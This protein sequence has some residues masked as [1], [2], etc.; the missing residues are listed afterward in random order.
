MGTWGYGLYENDSFCEVVESFKENIRKGISVTDIVTSLHD[1]YEDKADSCIVSLAI[2]ESLWRMGQLTLDVF[3]NVKYIIDSGIEAD[4]WR[5]LGADEEFINHRCRELEL[6]VMRLSHPPTSNQKWGEE[7][8]D[9]KL[10]KGTCFW[11]KHRG[12]I[13]GAVVVEELCT[14]IEYY[15]IAISEQVNSIPQT[16]SQ[17]LSLPVYTVAWFGT[18]DLLSA[19]RIHCVGRINIYKN[20]QNKYGLVIEPNRLVRNTNCGQ[21]YTWSHSYRQISFKDKKIGDFV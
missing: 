19:K 12:K 20:Y 9:V 5:Q 16:V 11:Y 2:A 1:K 21:T 8:A 10:Q 14:T 3:N 7:L 18:F 6:F 13:Y 17:M 4:Y 15:L